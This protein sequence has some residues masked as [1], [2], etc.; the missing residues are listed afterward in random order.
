MTKPLENMTVEELIEAAK[1][2]RPDW[3]ESAPPPQMLYRDPAGRWHRVNVDDQSNG[4][5]KMVRILYLDN[6]RRCETLRRNADGKRIRGS[7]ATWHSC[8]VYRHE[9]RPLSEAGQ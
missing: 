2:A 3:S 9:L 4:K 7:H 5:S 6:A 8:Y 1:N